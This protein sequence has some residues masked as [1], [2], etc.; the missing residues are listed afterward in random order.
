[1]GFYRNVD[2]LAIH[3]AR[4]AIM[5]GSG[6]INC[7]YTHLFYFDHI[8]AI[9]ILEHTKKY[10]SNQIQSGVTKRLLSNIDGLKLLT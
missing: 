7:S 2:S 10:K 4:N 5:F 3:A 1:M 8:L 6:G 9:C